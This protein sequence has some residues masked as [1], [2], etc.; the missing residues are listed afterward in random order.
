MEIKNFDDLSN[1][2]GCLGDTPYSVGRALYKYTDCGPWV[3]FLTE[4]TPA[5]DVELVA[6]VREQDGKVIIDLPEKPSKDFSNFLLFLGFSDQ[7]V[8]DLD[9]VKSVDDYY[10]LVTGF[11][12][13]EKADNL[14]AAKKSKSI[15]ISQKQHVS[16]DYGE[17]YYEDPE[18]RT[19]DTSK[20]VGIKIG[21]IVEGSDVEIGPETLMF[22]FSEEELDRVVK[23]IND[24]A[25]FYWDRDNADH[26]IL[27]DPKGEA[28][29]AKNVWGDWEWD[30]GIPE[31]IRK[32]IE[33]KI[34]E[35]GDEIEEEEKIA[36]LA[37]DGTW[38]MSKQDVGVSYP[39][40]KPGACP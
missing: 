20:I 6:T 38:E 28:H 11:I 3:T 18:A 15:V 5:H 40:L 31:E 13:A 36:I 16:A 1:A 2:I 4:K 21:S 8:C 24:E 30:E 25:S 17:I 35:E 29:F 7:G 14:F 37:S 26:Y 22:P 12:K 27:Y 10:K 9:D 19:C 32:L 23:G 39:R 33:T 34:E